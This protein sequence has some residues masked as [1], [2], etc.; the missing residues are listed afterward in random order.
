[1]NA[2]AGQIITAIPIELPGQWF[3]FCGSNVLDTASITQGSVFFVDGSNDIPVSP[4]IQLQPPSK[5]GEESLAAFYAAVP[6][7]VPKLTGTLI[8]PTHNDI[9]GQPGC[10]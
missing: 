4:P 10:N 9:T 5:I 1:M 7:N 2:S 8:G 3:C 6:N